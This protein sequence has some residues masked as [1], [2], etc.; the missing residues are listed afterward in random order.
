MPGGVDRVQQDTE[1]AVYG[2]AVDDFESPIATRREMRA[3]ERGH[4]DWRKGSLAIALGRRFSSSGYG[5]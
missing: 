4:A 3:R 2:G 1:F 5:H